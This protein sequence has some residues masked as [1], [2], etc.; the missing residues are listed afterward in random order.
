VRDRPLELPERIGD[1]GP[2]DGPLVGTAALA[3]EPE[4]RDGEREEQDRRQPE[5]VLHR[6]VEQEDQQ[7]DEHRP[8]IADPGA[9]P[10]QPA[11][12]LRGAHGLER[13]VVVDEGGLVGEVGDD[14]QGHAD[15]RRDVGDEEGGADAQRGEAQ[16]ERH[17]S[18]ATV[19]ERAEDGRHG[20]VDPDADHD[21]ERQH[22]VAVALAELRVLDQVQPDRA[23]H[24]RE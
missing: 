3:H 24:D 1:V 14:E 5:A 9:D 10:G 6:D 12:A 13:R 7:P 23:R 16:Q 22:D 20:G 8:A 19:G 4:D 21:R 11:P 18:P 2:G 15:D 17:P